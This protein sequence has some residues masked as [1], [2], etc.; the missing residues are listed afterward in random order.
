MNDTEFLKSTIEICDINASRL[1]AA[2][3]RLNKLLPLKP[4]TIENMSIDELGVLELLT[5]RFAKL[6]DVIGNK[7]FKS[8]IIIMGENK[9]DL[10]F[11]DRL[12]LLEKF[13]MLPS[14]QDWINMRELRNHITHEYPDNPELMVK[15]L[16]QATIYAANLINYW[17]TLREKIIKIIT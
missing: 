1:Q 16:N 12:N 9:P 11:I 4:D 10:T 3:L 14:K 8:V 13:E 6:Q 7:I 17:T 15:N 5:S 2:L